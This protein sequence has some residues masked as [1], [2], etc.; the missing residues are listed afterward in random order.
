MG[1]WANTLYHHLRQ[2]D[3][4]R[5]QTGGKL[6]CQIQDHQRFSTPYYPQGNGQ[7]DISNRTILD[8]LC[9]WQDKAKGKWVER[10]PEMLWAT[11]K[12]ILTGETPFS[13]AYGIEAIIP[14]DIYM[15]TL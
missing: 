14:L 7:T 10:L 15:P 5:Q 8:S 1:L 3:E 4:L 13:L 9:K 6:L 11:N 12:H 2:W